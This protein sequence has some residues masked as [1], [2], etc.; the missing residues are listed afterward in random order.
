MTVA[1]APA[2]WLIIYLWLEGGDDLD[3]VDEREHFEESDHRFAFNMLVDRLAVV[4]N[5]MLERGA[6]R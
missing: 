2:N 6:C 3:R 4:V 5:V 1:V